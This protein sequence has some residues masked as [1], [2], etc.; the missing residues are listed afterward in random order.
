MAKWNKRA[1]VTFGNAGFSST[2][3]AKRHCEAVETLKGYELAK[4]DQCEKKFWWKNRKTFQ[5]DLENLCM[6]QQ[7]DRHDKYKK[8]F[9]KGKDCDK[10]ESWNLKNWTNKKN[11]WENL[12][13]RKCKSLNDKGRWKKS[14]KLLWK[15]FQKLSDCKCSAPNYKVTNPAGI[16]VC[17]QI[18]SL[19]KASGGFIGSFTVFRS[20]KYDELKGK[21]ALIAIKYDEDIKVKIGRSNKND[22]GFFNLKPLFTFKVKGSGGNIILVSK[23]FIEGQLPSKKS[24]NKICIDDISPVKYKVK[25]KVGKDTKKVFGLKLGSDV[26]NIPI[27]KFIPS[28]PYSPYLIEP[29][30]I[31]NPDKKKEQPTTT[32]QSQ[33]QPTETSQSPDPNQSAPTNTVPNQLAPTNDPNQQAPTNPAPAD[34]APTD[35]APINDPNATN[36]PDPTP[37][38]QN[39]NQQDANSSS[40]SQTA[41]VANADST[42][43]AANDSV[44]GSSISTPPIGLIV[45][46]VVVAV[47]AAFVGYTTYERRRYRNQFNRRQNRQQQNPS[48]AAVPDFGRA[49]KSSRI[50]VLL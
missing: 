36:S 8:R 31:N 14:Q 10:S 12:D 41:Q 7:H 18:A 44:P 49:L 45:F 16:S 46:A 22:D 5:K 35:A 34:T 26:K 2:S 19:N 15:Q 38:N 20:L 32:T 43:A 47:G 3:R 1:I 13:Q 24:M 17:Y 33:D 21:P 42:A 30:P 23:A 50:K 40:A 37:A 25:V 27:S 39:S 29:S 48:L 11:T 9:H 6:K 4:I 28:K